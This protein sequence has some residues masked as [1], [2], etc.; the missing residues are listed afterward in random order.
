MDAPVLQHSNLEPVVM[1][2][3]ISKHSSMQNTM[4]ILYEKM[5]N[6]VIHIR[7]LVALA[8]KKLK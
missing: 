8:V 5:Q 7:L 6:K 1:N 4:A 3:V 2:S